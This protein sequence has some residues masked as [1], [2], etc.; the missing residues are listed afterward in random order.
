MRAATCFILLLLLSPAAA[1]PP[2]LSPGRAAKP[3]DRLARDGKMRGVCFVAGRR[4]D[5]DVFGPL[6]RDHVEWISQTPFGWMRGADSPEIRIAAAGDVYWGE[7]DE[8]LAATALAARKA[9]VR[10]LLKPHLWVAGW[11]DSVWSG[12][13]AMRSPSDWEA[14][15]RS[16]RKF[17]L[18][19]AELAEKHSFEALAVG[20][21]LQGTT[22]GHEAEWRAL[23]G[24][25]RRAY[26]G[27]LTYAANW[28]HEFEALPFWDALDFAGVQAY[29]P[30]TDKAD[31]TLQDLL[32][33]WKGPVALL[34]KVA[35][36]HR[37]DVVLTEVG[38]R[39]AD[40]AAVQPWLWKT[41]DRINL[42]LQ[43]RCYEAMF[44]AVWRKPWLKGIYAWKWFPGFDVSKS[45]A[46]DGFTPQGKP[47]EATLRLWYASSRLP[48]R[49]Q[50]LP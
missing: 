35:Q 26:R 2:K 50:T 49:P 32:D 11:H 40:R 22:L 3:E 16:Y 41:G 29:F 28:D 30:L 24:E 31:P 7:T 15:F 13:I 20:T 23:I 42:D 19:Y 4:I 10:T 48:A 8:G 9:G 39:S 12:E 37:R 1:L 33:G 44:R 27:K 21:E 17:I 14:W 18:H 5:P 6:Q 38:Y 25:V 46:D 43:A 34:E 45:A 36:Q 47:A